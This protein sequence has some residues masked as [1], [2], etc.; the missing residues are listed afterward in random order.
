MVQQI[1]GNWKYYFLGELSRE[2]FKISPTSFVDLQPHR[3]NI[4]VWFIGSVPCWVWII[5][6]WDKVCFYKQ[7]RFSIPNSGIRGAANNVL[8][9]SQLHIL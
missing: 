8:Y 1:S 4:Q 5:F 2:M 9:S 6:L 3:N 7:L